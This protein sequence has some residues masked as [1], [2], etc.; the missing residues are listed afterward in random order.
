MVGSSLP[1]DV[2]KDLCVKDWDPDKMTGAALRWV[3]EQVAEQASI[4][5][6]RTAI[7]ICS[8]LFN[9]S[10]HIFYFCN[11]APIKLLAFQYLLLRAMMMTLGQQVEEGLTNVCG[12]WKPQ[13]LR[14][15][16]KNQFPCHPNNPMSFRSK[17]E[18]KNW[19]RLWE[20]KLPRQKLTWK[21]VWEPKLSKNGKKRLRPREIVRLVIL[22]ISL[23]NKNFW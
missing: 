5:R 12:I 23:E 2:K 16:Q 3:T 15:K 4:W 10:L 8:S 9:A 11:F 22:N 6:I 20:I 14:S 7:S 1:D 13:K 18:P 17:H 21:F 19:M